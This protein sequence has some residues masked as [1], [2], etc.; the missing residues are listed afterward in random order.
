MSPGL[1]TVTAQ[2]QP[3]LEPGDSQAWAPESRWVRVKIRVKIMCAVHNTAPRINCVG[4]PAIE[5]L[6]RYQGYNLRW[7]IPIIAVHSPNQSETLQMAWVINTST[8]NA[9]QSGPF[10]SR[11]SN[12]WWSLISLICIHTWHGGISLDSCRVEEY[13][14]YHWGF[15]RG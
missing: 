15:T 5:F 10:P 13:C 2:W 1:F 3:S 4:D 6:L 7:L 8:C 11:A 12:H 9:W 14:H